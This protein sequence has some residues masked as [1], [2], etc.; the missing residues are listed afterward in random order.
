MLICYELSIEDHFNRF[1]F[2][3]DKND[4]GSGWSLRLELEKKTCVRL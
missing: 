3:S 2:S 1:T 4:S